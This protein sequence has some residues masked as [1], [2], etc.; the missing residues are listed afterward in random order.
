MSDIDEPIRIEVTL[1]ARFDTVWQAF[2]VPEAIRRWHGWEYDGLDAEIHCIYEE[3]T[4]ASQPDR[5]LE[6]GGHLFALDDRGDEV[7]VRVTRSLAAAESWTDYYDEIEQGW[8]GFLQQLRFA[9]ARHPGEDRRTVRLEG[10]ALASNPL[11]VIGT[12]G[13][14]AAAS[15]EVGK[16]YEADAA[17]GDDLVGEV[18]FRAPD[19]LGLTVDGWGDG[20]LVVTSSRASPG[21]AALTATTYG[22]DDDALTG[23]HDR[24]AATWFTAYGPLEQ[25]ELA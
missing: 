9:L 5:A 7:I 20:L 23:L 8:L 24:M 12:L 4:T 6:I 13:L 22:F 17:W 25:P 2:R 11:P 21:A 18:W 3:E 14:T 1:P 10:Q 19:Q 15:V 16:R